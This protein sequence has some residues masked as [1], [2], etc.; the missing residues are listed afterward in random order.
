MAH[1]TNFDTS[2]KFPD[3]ELGDVLALRTQ[4]MN[5]YGNYCL[6]GCC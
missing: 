6:L 5:K 4:R 1:M 3:E 2:L